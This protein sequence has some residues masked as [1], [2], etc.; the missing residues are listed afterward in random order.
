LEAFK[1]ALKRTLE[2]ARGAETEAGRAA[3]G[4]A[5]CV[6]HP[7]DL[8]VLWMINSSMVTGTR[9]YRQYLDNIVAYYAGQPYW[10]KVDWDL[11][12][13]ENPFPLYG[14]DRAQSAIVAADK[15]PG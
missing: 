8:G 9:V 6:E 14:L 1:D 13:G 7:T 2:L 5:A 3:A 4:F 12:F 15:E 10:N 11:L